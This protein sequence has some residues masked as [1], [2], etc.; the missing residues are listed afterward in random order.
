M[1]GLYILPTILPM[2]VEASFCLSD[3]LR[4]VALT[5]LTAKATG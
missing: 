2:V 3:Q 4:F 5:K 1:V